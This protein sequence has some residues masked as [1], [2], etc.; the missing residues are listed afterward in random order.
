[1]QVFVARRLDREMTHS[2][3]HAAGGLGRVLHL[4]GVDAVL[5]YAWSL[6]RTTTAPVWVKTVYQIIA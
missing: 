2:Y 6:A 4:Q 5:V 3:L 1:M